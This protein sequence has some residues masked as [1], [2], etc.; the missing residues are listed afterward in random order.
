MDPIL[1]LDGV[2]KR[3]LS[4]QAV[5][6]V[7]LS[8]PRGSFY[9]LVGPSGCGK[10]TTLRLI[11]GFETPDAGVIELE[12]RSIVDDKP[13]ERNVS[14][15][16]QSYALFPHLTVQQNIEFGLRRRSA[17]D[18]DRRTREAI[19]LV[20]LGGKE[21]RLP[22]QLS[23]GEKQRVALARSLVTEPAV[24]LLDEP[25]SALDP[26]LREQV[27]SELKSL[28]RRVGT[29]FLFITHDRAEALSMSDSLAV[30]NGGKLE[31]SGTPQEMYLHPRTKFVA[32]F[33]G[34]VNWIDGVGVR[35]EAL[36]LSAPSDAAR[37][38]QVQVEQIVFLGDCVQIHTRSKLDE[39]VTAQVSR[40]SEI[41]VTGRDATLWW[42]Q[43][44]E[45]RCD[46]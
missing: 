17:N 24:L 45:L 26:N 29:T 38:L 36:H 4:H 6:R 14:T 20:Q 30:M 28:Q 9:G 7:S 39:A 22:S 18:V 34:A 13:Y 23:G 15:V 44:E 37:S 27:R 12:G 10:T 21:S 40:F 43:E 5:D 2:S 42:R 19:E 46:A 16:F 35:P 11:A 25:L 33:L 31:Q 8:I 3:F 41:P 32:S 1:R